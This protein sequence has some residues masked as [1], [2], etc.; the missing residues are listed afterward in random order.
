MR[1]LQRVPLTSESRRE[2]L[3]RGA[4]PSGE[5]PAARRY[6]TQ[7]AMKML[8]SRGPRAFRV[9]VKTNLLPSRENIGKLSKRAP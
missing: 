4:T 1:R 5:K 7:S 3:S 9:E 6:G 8:N 2:V